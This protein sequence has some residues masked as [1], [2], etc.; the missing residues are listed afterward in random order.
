MYFLRLN[1]L[2]SEFGSG[3]DLEWHNW[4]WLREA[5]TCCSH[6]NSGCLVSTHTN[7]HGRT[8]KGSIS[9]DG[10]F[11]HYAAGGYVCKQNNAKIMRKY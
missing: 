7:E 4:R 5:A 2:L 1:V 6:D 3:S 9:T 10:R 11:N 8:C